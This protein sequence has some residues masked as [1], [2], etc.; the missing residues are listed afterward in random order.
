MITGWRSCGCTFTQ[1]HIDNRLQK[2]EHRSC[3]V[4]ANSAKWACE[5]D[6]LQID[7]ALSASVPEEFNVRNR[8]CS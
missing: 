8:N 7:L 1:V 5:V 3:H 4:C 2:L 6:P